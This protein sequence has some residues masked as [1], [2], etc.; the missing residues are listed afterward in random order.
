MVVGAVVS[1]AAAGVTS[2]DIRR[3]LIA[4]G[5][6]PAHRQVG[7][8]GAM[9]REHLAAGSD[10]ERWDALVTLAERDPI[11]P[12]ARVTRERIA[13]RILEGAGLKVTRAG[14]RLSAADPGALM[15]ERD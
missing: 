6:A 4:V 11:E 9:L 15:G 13:R 5:V 3:R 1:T 8:A 14:G 2:A 10:G 12:L 7:L